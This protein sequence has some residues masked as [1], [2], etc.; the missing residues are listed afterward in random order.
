MESGMEV[1]ERGTYGQA[2]DDHLFPLQAQGQQA[3]NPRSAQ[4]NWLVWTI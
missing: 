1:V 3:K 4:L 2:E